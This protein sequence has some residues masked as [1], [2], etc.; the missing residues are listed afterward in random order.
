MLRVGVRAFI[1]FVC[2]QGKSALF[3]VHIELLCVL[4]SAHPFPVT[5]TDIKTLTTTF[6]AHEC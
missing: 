3:N 6:V 1:A 5:E 2:T 4:R